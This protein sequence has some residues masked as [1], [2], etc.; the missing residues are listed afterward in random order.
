MARFLY[1]P[2]QWWPGGQVIARAEAAGVPSKFIDKCV[3]KFRGQRYRDG[4]VLDDVF[5]RRLCKSWETYRRRS[6]AQKNRYRK[7]PEHNAGTYQA[8]DPDRVQAAADTVNQSLT[9][10]RETLK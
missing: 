1:V 4:D 7:R 2:I 5:F 3:G 9:K 6:Q 8:P 10:I